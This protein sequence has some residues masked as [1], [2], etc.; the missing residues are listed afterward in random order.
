MFR[1]GKWGQHV[2]EAHC[3]VPIPLNDSG[4]P[5]ISAFTREISGRIKIESK[6][7]HLWLL[8]PLGRLLTRND[9]G[10]IEAYSL[11]NQE[12]EESCPWFFRTPNSPLTAFSHSLGGPM[13]L[14]T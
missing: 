8:F 12:V 2:G 13:A 10:I 11:Q 1:W 6:L 14:S 9:F 5:F 3:V 4:F 7:G